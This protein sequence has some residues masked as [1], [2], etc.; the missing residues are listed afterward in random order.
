[1]TE[2]VKRGRGWY[3]KEAGSEERKRI[4]AMGGK[5]QKGKSGSNVFAK[6]PE[7]AREAGKKGGLSVPREN[8]LLV[9]DPVRA[10]EIARLGGL[11]LQKKR[12]EE[13]ALNDT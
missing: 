4:A 3:L 12:R 1:M 9:R 7:L 8:R 5:A 6:D 10:R 11:A 2:N 13:K